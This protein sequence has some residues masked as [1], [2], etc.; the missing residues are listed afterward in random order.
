MVLPSVGM[1]VF[2]RCLNFFTE[3]KDFFA[4]N[5][6]IFYNRERNVEAGSFVYAV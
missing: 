1:A 4:L 5:S 6:N 2:S 3:N